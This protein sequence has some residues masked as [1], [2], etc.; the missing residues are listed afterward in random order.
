MTQPRAVPKLVAAG[1]LA[2]A[3][4]TF[5]ATPSAASGARLECDADGPNQ[6]ALHARYEERVRTTIT[7]KKFDAQFEALAG[8]GFSAGQRITFLV[9]NVAVGSEPLKVIVGRELAA[10]LDLDSP[11]DGGKPLP[12]NWPGIHAGSSVKAKLGTRVLLGCTVQ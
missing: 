3:A 9:D 6:T 7:R 8:G 5:N 2:A 4:V 10:E 1:L 12:A 11:R